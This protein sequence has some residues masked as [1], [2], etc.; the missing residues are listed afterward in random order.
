MGINVNP[1][2]KVTVVEIRGRIVEG[3]SASELDKALRGLI[4]EKK[5]NTILDV[6]EMSW[7]D[8]TAIGILVSHY[9][10]AKKLD[11][12]VLLLKANEKVKTLM[13][14]VHLNERFGWA[15][16]MDEALSWFENPAS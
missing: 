3:E 11:G 5:V 15:D 13:K 9:V 16:E 7:F 2:D 1:S 12:R 10:S 6:S 4:R 8:S 14:L